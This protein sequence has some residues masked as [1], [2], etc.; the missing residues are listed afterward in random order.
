MGE[1]TL[2]Q[3]NTIIAAALSKGRGMNLPPLSVAVLDSGGHVK[4]IV[5]EDGQSFMR[6]RVAQSKAWGALALGVHSRHIAERYE[7]GLRQEGFIGALNDLSG[8]QV[9]PLPGAVLVRREGGVIGAVGV[10]GAASEDDELC[11]VAGVEA[12]GVSADLDS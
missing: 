5:R 8:G 2:E 6:V 9:I 4:A 11:A 7:Q 3:A 10:A 12:I 1:I